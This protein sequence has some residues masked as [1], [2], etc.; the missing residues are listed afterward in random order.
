[1]LN[2]NTRT[3]RTQR[4]LTET[5][6]LIMRNACIAIQSLLIERAW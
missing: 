6:S 5:N 1:M 3:T 4:S 2:M